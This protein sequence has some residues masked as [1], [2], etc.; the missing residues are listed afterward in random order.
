MVAAVPD[1]HRGRASRT[2]DDAVTFTPQAQVT[3]RIFAMNLAGLTGRSETS[4]SPDMAAAL[5][6]IAQGPDR[7]CAANVDDAAGAFLCGCVGLPRV[8]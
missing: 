5:E 4:P 8:Q 3:A 7:G 6:A 1:W 2:N